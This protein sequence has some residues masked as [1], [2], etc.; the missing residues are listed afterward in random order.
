[1]AARYGNCGTELSEGMAFCPNCGASVSGEGGKPEAGI[2][3]SGPGRVFVGALLAILTTSIVGYGVGWAL[4]LAPAPTDLTAVGLVLVP[5]L[6]LFAGAAALQLRVPAI[7]RKTSIFA[8]IAWIAV[9]GVAG[10]LGSCLLVLGG[11]LGVFSGGGAGWADY[12]IPLAGL[13][14]AALVLWGFA[15]SRASRR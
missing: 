9:A 12:V 13:L 10:F 4:S 1:M 3:A 11:V 8:V 5:V 2:P 6:S 15:L 14:I 7:R